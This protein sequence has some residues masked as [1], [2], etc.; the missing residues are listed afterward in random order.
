MPV[1]F[2]CRA[3]LECAV[4]QPIL[5]ERDRRNL[6]HVAI[7]DREGRLGGSSPWDHQS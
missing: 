1:Q 5:G 7:V 2:A 3:K 4:E 6:G